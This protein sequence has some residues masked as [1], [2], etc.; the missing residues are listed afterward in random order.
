MTKRM[1]LGLAIVALAMCTFSIAAMAQEGGGQG[2]GRGQRGGRGPVSVDDQIARMSEQLNLT[3][4]QKDKI[5]P[6]LEDSRKQGQALR[7]DANLSQDDRRAKMMEIRKTSNEKIRKVLNADQ[8][9]KFDEM[10]ER[11]RQGGPGG[12]GGGRPPQQ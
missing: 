9:K 2:Q 12:Q 10:Q 1:I 4:A 11:M 7:D 3:D 6:I 8:Q 5:K